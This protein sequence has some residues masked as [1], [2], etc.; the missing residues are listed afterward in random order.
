MCRIGTLALT[1][2]VVL[3]SR[4]V[5]WS[6]SPYPRSANSNSF[7]SAETEANRLSALTAWLWS[8][9]A[10]HFNTECASLRGLPYSRSKSCS[11]GGE[12]RSRSFS[13]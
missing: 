5:S 8:S 3:T 10:N 4:R 13:Q 7:R 6:Q 9:S 11:W 2:E 12:L 1:T